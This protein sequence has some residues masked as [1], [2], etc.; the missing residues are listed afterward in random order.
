MTFA[1]VEQTLYFLLFAH[2][3]GELLVDWSEVIVTQRRQCL[4]SK[5][6]VESYDG[7]IS[8]DT[9]HPQTRFIVRFPKHVSPAARADATR[10][11]GP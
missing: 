2:A 4:I 10:Q 8:L 11:S 9:T 5:R 3:A 7:T 6:I 1:V